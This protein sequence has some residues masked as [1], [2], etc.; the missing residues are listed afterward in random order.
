MDDKVSRDLE[1]GDNYTVYRS[2]NN[3]YISL[4]A[5]EAYFDSVCINLTRGEALQLIA[6]VLDAVNELDS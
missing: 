3:K 1:Q 5:D 4:V 2:K 6:D